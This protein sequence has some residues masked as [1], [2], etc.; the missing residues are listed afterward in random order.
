MRIKMN[1][2]EDVI[3]DTATKED[4]AELVRLRIAYMI[5]DFGSITECER[6]CMEKQLPDYF[7]RRLGKELIAF[8][9]RTEGRLVAAVYLL[10]IEKPANPF[11]PNGLD[12]EVL[13]VYT[14]EPYRGKGICTRLMKNMIAWAKAHHICRI[15]LVATQDGYPVYKKAGFEDKK[16]KYVDMRLRLR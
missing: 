10:I 9:A 7:E 13:S 15:D 4:I 12:S 1:K 16:Q 2:T 11:L 8:V 3:F 5:D 14:E 6:D